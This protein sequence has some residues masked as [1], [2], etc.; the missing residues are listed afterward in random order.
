[1]SAFPDLEGFTGIHF[2]IHRICGTG[3]IRIG[4]DSCKA[5]A[6]NVNFR[7]DVYK[8]FFCVLY[9]VFNILLCIKAAVIS[10]FIVSRRREATK[11]ANLFYIPC[12]HFG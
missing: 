2:V 3:K 7:Q 9:D 1:M 5:V 11:M 10:W 6:G 8:P 12:S 4:N